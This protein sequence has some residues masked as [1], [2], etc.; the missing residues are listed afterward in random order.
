VLGFRRPLEQA[1][2]GIEEIPG[3][4]WCCGAAVAACSYVLLRDSADRMMTGR[5]DYTLKVVFAVAA[6]GWREIDRS[7]R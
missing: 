7:R 6:S 1:A 5:L 3:L 2:H 4:C